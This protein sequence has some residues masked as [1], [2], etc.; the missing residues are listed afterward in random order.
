MAL[1]N[2]QTGG[3]WK[4]K[5]GYRVDRLPYVAVGD[6][7][8]SR[9][10]EDGM[11]DS[12]SGIVN[13]HGTPAEY[14]DMRSD[15]YNLGPPAAGVSAPVQR[16]CLPLETLEAQWSTYHCF[17]AIQHAA[18]NNFRMP[19][20]QVPLNPNSGAIALNGR[21]RVNGG[22]RTRPLPNGTV[23]GWQVKA[24]TPGAVSLRKTTAPRVKDF[25]P[26]ELV[27]LN[28]NKMRALAHKYGEVFGVIMNHGFDANGHVFYE[29]DITAA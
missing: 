18:G 12:R 14:A 16:D 27:A 1:R 7:V 24:P 23:V 3:V 8:L 20:E 22:A 26:A 19:G 9:K 11:A 29:V 2:L 5:G 4:P 21:I 13:C 6:I 10:P 17:G 15:V 25:L 28:S